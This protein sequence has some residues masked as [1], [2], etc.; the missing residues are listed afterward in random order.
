MQQGISVERDVG[1]TPKTASK[2]AVFY[3]LPTGTQLLLAQKNP[4]SQ[5]SKS[6][7]PPRSF[8]ISLPVGRLWS[9]CTNHLLHAP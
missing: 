9:Q 8:R 2:A 4:P 7:K 6:L 1:T 3:R 5:P